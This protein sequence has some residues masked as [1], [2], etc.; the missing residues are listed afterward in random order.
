VEKNP[1]CV[2]Q[3]VLRKFLEPLAATRPG[4]LR[5]LIDRAVTIHASEI[6]VSEVRVDHIRPVS[7]SL[8]AQAVCAA[9]ELSTP[10]E[11]KQAVPCILLLQTPKVSHVHIT[12]FSV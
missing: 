7:Y 5:A 2:T 4:V 1:Q 9:F 11:R 12:T 3:R 6:V 10:N 8:S